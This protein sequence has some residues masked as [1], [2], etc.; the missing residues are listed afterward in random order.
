MFPHK[1][2]YSVDSDPPDRA[3]MIGDNRWLSQ[4]SF[5]NVDS[6]KIDWAAL[7]QQWIHMKEACHTIPPDPPM[8]PNAPPPPRISVQI[9]DYEEQGEAPMEVEHDD[10]PIPVNLTAPPPPTN[11]FANAKNW[12]NSQNDGNRQPK[13]WSNK[14]TVAFE[15]TFS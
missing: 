3:Q 12:T 14:S 11:I 9:R 6:E 4:N 10:E 2:L 13:Q 7:A 5:Q 15:N 8:I 1:N